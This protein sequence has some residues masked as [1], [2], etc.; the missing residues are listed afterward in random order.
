ML[1]TLKVEI[2]ISKLSEIPHTGVRRAVMFLGLGLNAAYREDLVDYQLRNLPI[3]PGQT[4]I[5]IDF[6]PDNLPIEQ[7]RKY[8]EEFSTWIISCGIREL[9][10]HYALFLDKIHLYCLQ[11]LASKNFSFAFD[12]IN[13]HKNFVLSNGLPGKL[14]LLRERF[15]IDP[16]Y[17]DYIKKL[18][19]ARNCLTH[20]LGI[21][22]PKHCGENGLFTV[23]WRSFDVILFDN[24]TKEE[25]PI[26]GAIG[27]TVENGG[28]ISIR[29]CVREKKFTPGEK[30][31]FNQQDLWEVCYF[32]NA[33]A[34]PSM[35]TSFVDF[36]KKNDVPGAD[37]D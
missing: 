33:F 21:V 12:P 30:I 20:D 6:F 27:L 31:T 18:Y 3:L 37:T 25:I 7:I 1:E 36:L 22:K 11:T 28:Q 4:G 5:P 23:S 2:D 16:N 19:I 10:E 24:K 14:R 13:S 8:K 26:L 35:T 17:S 9:L 32:F 15:T 34:I 29:P